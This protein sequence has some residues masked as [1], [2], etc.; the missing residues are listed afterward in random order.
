MEE[1]VPVPNPMAAKESCRGS[2]IR[3][4]EPVQAGCTPEGHRRDGSSEPILNPVGL[5]RMKAG[6]DVSAGIP[7]GQTQHV[8]AL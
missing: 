6:K 8:A 3:T 5:D 4:T 2:L 1:S 7:A